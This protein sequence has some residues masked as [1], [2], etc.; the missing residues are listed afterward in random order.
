AAVVEA[1]PLIAVFHFEG[2]PPAQ[3]NRSRDERAPLRVSFAVQLDLHRLD[4][5]QDLLPRNIGEP[6]SDIAHVRRLIE[7]AP[8]VVAQTRD[9]DT[10]HWSER[11]E[12]LV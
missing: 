5:V 9:L 10:H 11:V 6:F 8:L 2:Q 7:N 4:P 3:R 12:A 1:E